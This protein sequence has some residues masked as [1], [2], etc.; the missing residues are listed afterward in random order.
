MR[1][2]SVTG[3]RTSVSLRFSCDRSFVQLSRRAYS[4][5]SHASR[6]RR[7]PGGLVA[8]F[9]IRPGD[10]LPPRRSASSSST[11]PRRRTRQA[12]FDSDRFRR[13]AIPSRRGGRERRDQPNANATQ[14]RGFRDRRLYAAESRLHRQS[15]RP[16]AADS[17][18]RGRAQCSELV[19]PRLS[20]SVQ[21]VLD[22]SGSEG[23]REA[24][25]RRLVAFI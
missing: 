9:S 24:V 12:D 8:G 23:G 4:S 16:S 21:G 20:K 13:A 10:Q 14:P 6:R 18:G 3:R 25:G 17:V 2:H 7:R 22:R 1:G 11:A 15:D 5:F 19:L